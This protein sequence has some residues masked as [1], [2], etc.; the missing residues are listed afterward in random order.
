MGKDLIF[1]Y[2]FPQ[3]KLYFTSLSGS[4]EQSYGSSLLKNLVCFLSYGDN[5]KR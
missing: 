5:W 2:F 1:V 3:A 4:A